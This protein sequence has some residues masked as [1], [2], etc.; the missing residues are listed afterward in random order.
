V[1]SKKPTTTERSVELKEETKDRDSAMPLTNIKQY[2][3]KIQ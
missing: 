2:N 1:G 3:I